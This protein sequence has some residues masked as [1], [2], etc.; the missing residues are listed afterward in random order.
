M[1]KMEILWLV[2]MLAFLVAEG[3]CAIHL[4]SVWF[5]AGSLAA[6]IASLLSAPVW[7]QVLLFVAVSGALLAAFW[8][9]VRKYM[10]PKLT[11]TN[12]DAVIGTVGRVTADIDNVE[13][14]GQVKLGA[15]EW[16]ARSVSGERISAGSLVR[17]ERVEG[18][19]V[20]VALAEVTATNK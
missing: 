17:V 16:S 8:P 11:K 7:L 10:N 12:V 15:M 18:V 4:V 2:L 9:L 5:V 14:S 1:E 19:K 20:F 6:L 3:V 13:A